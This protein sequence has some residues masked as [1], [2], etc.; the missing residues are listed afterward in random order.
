[1]ED[2]GG[3]QVG[4]VHLVIITSMT[5][6]LTSMLQD[7]RNSSSGVAAVMKDCGG[8]Q[9]DGRK[10]LVYKCI[11]NDRML[12]WWYDYDRYATLIGGC[13]FV[14]EQRVSM[15]RLKSSYMLKVV[16]S[17]PLNLQIVY[18]AAIRASMNFFQITTC[19]ADLRYLDPHLLLG[20]KDADLEIEFY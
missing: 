20:K 7:Q 3:N 6:K 2:G 16:L 13:T 14:K 11:Y 8:I 18:C 17:Y 1:M 15:V 19:S 4:R 10:C 12:F 9:V 5:Y